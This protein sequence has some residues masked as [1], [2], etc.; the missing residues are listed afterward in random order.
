MN[1]KPFDRFGT[2][3][4]DDVQCDF[5]EHQDEQETARINK[6]MAEQFIKFFGLLTPGVII[7]PSPFQDWLHPDL[8]EAHTITAPGFPD[9]WLQMK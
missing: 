5:G 4:T 9:T 7:P 1:D 3:I 6:L 8:K 2:F